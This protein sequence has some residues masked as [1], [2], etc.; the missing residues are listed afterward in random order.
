MKYKHIN[1]GIVK[2]LFSAMIIVALLALSSCN[3]K[4]K[5]G[6]GFSPDTAVNPGKGFTD[7]SA[8][9]VRVFDNNGRVCIQQ[10]NTS[11]E[12]VTIVEGSGKT[13]VLLK[14]KK[15]ELCFADSVNKDKVYEITAKSVLD[16]KSINWSVSFVATDIS[17]KDNTVIA[18]KEGADNENDYIKRYSL[19]DGKEVFSCSYADLEVKIPNVINKFFVG[20]TSKKAA[21]NPL[22]SL[23]D[24]NLVG[25]VRLGSREAPIDSFKV[26]L[27]RSKLAD[28]LLNSVPDLLLVAGNETTTAIDDG[29]TIILMHANAQTQAKDVQGFGVKFTYYYGDDNET[30]NIFVPVVAGKYDLAHATY[31]KDVFELSSF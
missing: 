19:L 20:Y 1:F 12:V 10:S 21:S 27:K 6:N 31:D 16:S 5:E 29:R 28:K 9:S 30:I 23:N 2:S 13:P 17:F 18:T 15:T 14:I 24:E 22:A 4:P 26:K 8:S 25:V 3:Q 11:Y 7:T